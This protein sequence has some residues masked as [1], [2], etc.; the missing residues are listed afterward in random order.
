MKLSQ[1]AGWKLCAS[2]RTIVYKAK[3]A[4]VQE[5]SEL[6]SILISTLTPDLTPN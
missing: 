3:N 6:T 2:R 1:Q 5:R 4:I